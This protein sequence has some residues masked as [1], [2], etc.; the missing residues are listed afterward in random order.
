MATRISA[1][2]ALWTI[3]GLSA[4]LRLVLAGS[5]GAFTNESYYYLYAKHLDW[6]YFDHPP[7]TALVAALGLK[8][9][10]G[11]SP[12]FGLR[13]GF[14]S[15]FAGST[16][17]LARLTTR[18]FGPRAGVIAAL[19]LNA[20]VFYGLIV[21]TMS[22]PDGPLLF[23][24]LLTLDRL[25]AA[26]D[27]PERKSIWIAAGLG[28]GGAMLSKYYAILL[29]AGAA[30]YI[31]LRPAT[32]QC[33]RKPGPYLALAVSLVVFSPVIFWNATHEWAS[34]A[35][36]SGRAS[37][38]T[39][40]H[41]S[42]FL[43]AM[44]AQ[45]LFLTPWVFLTLLIVVARLCHRRSRGWSDE[46]VFLTCQ[47]APAIILFLGISAFQRI[48]PHWPMIGFVALMPL[49]GRNLAERLSRIPNWT[50]P[51]IAATFVSAVPFAIAALIFIQARTG[52]LGGSSGRLLGFVV[53]RADPTL[54]LIRW[55]QIAK[56]LRNRGLLDD[57]NVFLFTDHWRNSA[58]LALAT[59]LPSRTACYTKDARAFRFWSQAEDYLGRD[60]VYVDVVDKEAD[61]F[62]YRPWFATIELLGEVPI[63]RAGVTLEKVRLFRCI[64][65][66]SP[67]EFGWAG[68]DKVPK[69]ANGLARR[70]SNTVFR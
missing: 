31:L 59:R 6:G 28:L 5:L 21:G 2:A 19:C 22:S 49:L 34:F 20:T 26:F 1:R 47:A 27:Q 37:E 54:D 32:W 41:P 43:E 11:I 15:L 30:L 24:W 42:M 38:S 53:A 67:F 23:F 35:Y 57:P 40:F 51:I 33:L 60:G 61:P 65:Q 66:T 9:A 50:R 70:P 44:A 39:G 10:G 25:A 56:E 62:D 14:I 45:V 4:A 17:L 58:Q 13:L 46:E 16:F 68:V 29:P 55:G 63:V 3:I 12:E 8:L 69:P 7:M 48:M 52:L 36:Q 64:S 18:F